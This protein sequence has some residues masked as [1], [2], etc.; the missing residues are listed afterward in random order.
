MRASL[1]LCAA[2]SLCGCS[3]DLGADGAGSGAPD[4]QLGERGDAGAPDAVAPD[5]GLTS[6]AVFRDPDL[7]A[8]GG[9]G[10]G[11]G[12]DGEFGTP[13]AE[14]S[15]GNGLD[16][17]VGGGDPDAGLDGRGPACAP[18]A[19]PSLEIGR[20]H[21]LFE[22]IPEASPLFIRPGSEGGV[23]LRFDLAA[24]GPIALATSLETLVESEGF[25]VAS[26]YAE[27]V[28]FPCHPSGDR[29]SVGN[30]VD[31]DGDW[32]LADLEGLDATLIVTARYLG[33]DGNEAS[34]EARHRGILEVGID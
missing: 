8:G 10:G 3:A 28:V 9:S 1:V 34:V 17:A 2:L 12:T 7:G 32:L 33:D 20:F 23:T 24:T 31:F 26:A 15:S 13:D 5:A 25:P 19:P 30:A 29:I 14:L 6:D 16:G 27:Q 18:D 4:G 11:G 22:P 21:Q